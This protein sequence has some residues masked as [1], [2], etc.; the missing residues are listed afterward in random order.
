MKKTLIFVFALC[1]FFVS[2]TQQQSTSF[3]PTFS[4]ALK[5]NASLRQPDEKLIIAANVA[6]VG[7]TPL[8]TKIL[9]LNADGTRDDSFDA[10]I[11]PDQDVTGLALQA[12]GKVL[13][14]GYFNSF[15]GNSAFK[16]LVRLNADGSLD[17]SFVIDIGY[18]QIR[19]LAV[20]DDGKIIVR[21][22]FTTINGVAAG[23]IARLHADGSID[24]TFAASVVVP[25]FLQMRM[26]T[27]IQDDDKIIIGGNFTQVNGTAVT[28]IARLNSDGSLDST[29]AL[30]TISGGESF[31]DALALQNGKIL[32]GGNFTRINSA[33]NNANRL[34]RLNADGTHDTSFSANPDIP[35]FGTSRV[36]S[37]CVL[38][39]GRILAGG[40]FNA[41]IRLFT[42]DGGY[43]GTFNPGTGFDNPSGSLREVAD[44]YALSGDTVLLTGTFTSYQS[45]VRQGV[46]KISLTGALD[47][48]DPLLGGP[49]SIR[50]VKEVVQGGTNKVY[51]S[52]D[53]VR[54]NGV[55][56]EFLVRLLAS[57]GSIDPGFQSPFSNINGWVDEIKALDVQSDGKLVLG[58]WFLI[59]S[60]NTHS[61]I[62][63]LNVDGT[64][65]ETFLTDVA[66]SNSS[67]AVSAVDVLADDKIIV[68]G[69]FD[70]I[71]GVSKANFVRLNADGSLDNTFN[72][73]NQAMTVG[74]L[75]RR[76]SD[77]KFLMLHQHWTGGEPLV[78][79]Y[80]AEGERD[81][82]FFVDDKFSDW[83]LPNSSGGASINAAI[84]HPNGRI[85]LGGTFDNYG[86]DYS[87]NNIVVVNDAGERDTTFNN[88]VPFHYQ[89]LPV[90]IL[91][92]WNNKILAGRLTSTQE[93]FVIHD[94]RGVL[95]ADQGIRGIVRTIG[96]GA[97]NRLY[98]GG[99]VSSIAGVPVTGL[100]A[101]E[102][103]AAVGG[104]PEN[105][106]VTTTEPRKLN[107]LWSLGSSNGHTGFEIQRSTAD[108]SNFVTVAYTNANA[109][110]FTD[111]GLEPETAYV[112]RIRAVNVATQ[113]IFS[114]TA[115][116]V[117][118]PYPPSHL[119][120]ITKSVDSKDISITWNDLDDETGYEIDWSED[121]FNFSLLAQLPANDTTYT[122]T[123]PQPQTKYYFRIR[124][125][126]DGGYGYYTNFIANSGG[127]VKMPTGFVAQRLG[128]T[129][130]KLTWIDNST[131]ETSFL[132][133]RY[134]NGKTDTT[135]V[136]ADE[137]TLIVEGLTPEN[138]YL[139][140][141]SA[142][143][144]EGNSNK[145]NTSI[146]PDGIESG[147]WSEPFF[148]GV[149]GRG[150]GVAFA[151]GD[152]GY[153]A[154]GQNASGLLKDLW[155]FDPSDST[156]TA[157]AEF[158]GTARIGAVAFVVNGKA[159][160]GTGND[161]SG[162]GFRRDFYAYDPAFNSWQ[163]VADFPEDFTSAAGIT[164]GV[165][166]ATDSLGYVGLGNTGTNNTK[167]F[168]RYDPAEN[169]WTAI[170]EFTAPGRTGA[171]AFTIQGRCYV[172]FGYAG[173]SENHRDIWE[174]QPAN[175]EWIQHGDLQGAGRGGV[176]SMSVGDE[177]YI[178][179][180]AEGGFSNSTPTNAVTNFEGSGFPS[181]LA[182]F[183]GEK[184][185]SAVAFA[186]GKY[187]YLFGG[188]NDGQY[189]SDFFK[190]IPGSTLIPAQP[191]SLIAKYESP[192]SLTITW[193][194]QADNESYFI[195]QFKPA[196]GSYSLAD[197]I[198]ANVTTYTHTGLTENTSY[199]YR[200]KAV[201]TYGSSAYVYSAPGYT[202]PVPSA[203]T[204]VQGE[205][206]SGN[207]INLTWEST[208][209]HVEGFV[210]FESVSGG[211]FEEITTVSAS[212]RTYKRTQLT[213]LTNYTYKIKSYGIAGQSE[214]SNAVEIQTTDIAPAAPTFFQITIESPVRLSLT[215]TDQS[216]NEDGFEIFRKEGNA[217]PVS[218]HK[219]A[220]NVTSWEDSTVV[221][222]IAYTYSIVSFNEIGSSPSTSSSITIPLPLPEV[223]AELTAENQSGNTI[224]LSWTDNDMFEES[225]EIHRDD[226]GL[227]ATVNADVTTYDDEDFTW[228]D[229]THT[230]T[231]RGKNKTGTSAFSNAVTITL[232]GV[233]TDVEQ[234]ENEDF[235]IYPNPVNGNKFTI[236]NRG[237]SVLSITVVNAL[238]QNIHA[239][240]I[241]G[242]SE[243][244][245]DCQGWSSGVY[246]VR[247]HDGKI[248]RISKQ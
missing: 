56:N 49:A 173:L 226:I 18:D 34:A 171:T 212:A 69:K 27:L 203:P 100:I 124:A 218:V 180:G 193:N 154:L 16:R 12:D 58:G 229:R 30:N 23:G 129:K 64:I 43:V 211:F 247:T 165:A 61:C 188:Y 174:Y 37:I 60:P 210:I 35:T 130:I 8:T 109:T 179:G 240:K 88:P 86:G 96:A 75:D 120:W 74:T 235:A 241:S 103:D 22:S 191:D 81:T 206:E 1:S 224:R 4:G 228:D 215:W 72:V 151:I 70:M 128:P 115:S 176:T 36:S 123:V 222:E 233:V 200:I 238:G 231:V 208:S 93:S 217:T 153:I 94:E 29:F 199:E 97:D 232:D 144:P 40:N 57:D 45:D 236:S 87:T 85:I 62:L 26:P 126:N 156:W 201:N 187:G 169:T 195:L 147:E 92:T 9:R 160:V 107:L 202:T 53:F 19:G 182:G 38:A 140:Y 83:R 196:N 10:G 77:G 24:E 149:P 118:Y 183:P 113:G 73:S 172:A 106:E 41:G 207:V 137:T 150:N 65:D 164:S 170:S 3:N 90:G 108:T 245:I 184:R 20:Q 246:L 223:P 48:F 237:A 47:S 243:E 112:Y 15:N 227:L 105:L 225:F 39:D 63:R 141:V 186:V 55:A 89:H 163:Q 181:A 161:L 46:A 51:V 7:S 44:I 155:E 25:G 28:G 136:A 121:G 142:T 59:T 205:A 234:S 6:I 146:Q 166:F 152:K 198:D 216:G 14:A 111:S 17:E 190:F 50:I 99:A 220:M 209:D 11:G 31:V 71:N 33:V 79:M 52:G 76:A 134:F 185:T 101:L 167:A 244:V 213:P 114:D 54:V 21:G 242:N 219:T 175:D 159:Y 143:H 158:P 42:A 2:Y 131:E 117:T 80:T 157:R 116:G 132:V 82:S 214:F 138:Y 104:G 162:N 139:F 135:E 68:G 119:T 125:F 5:V 66:S 192:T 194:D 84:F 110:S 230:Y 127:A 197:T 98:V 168:Y 204:N 32:I 102:V 145:A 248:R 133:E 91:A 122:A 148:P 67:E 221:P 177:A 78:S 13:V 95:F 239:A 189:L 178:I